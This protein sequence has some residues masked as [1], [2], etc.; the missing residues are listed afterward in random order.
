MSLL[1]NQKNFDCHLARTG[2]WL[3]DYS[4]SCSQ[5]NSQENNWDFEACWRVNYDRSVWIFQ[6]PSSLLNV[7]I[8][9]TVK[10]LLGKKRTWLKFRSQHQKGPNNRGPNKPPGRRSHFK[11][12]KTPKRRFSNKGEW[13]KEWTERWGLMQ[14][15]ASDS[16]PARQ[17]IPN[18][19]RPSTLRLVS[20]KYHGHRKW[21]AGRHYRQATLYVGTKT[22]K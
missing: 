4:S 19:S 21:V 3:S 7:S 1:E 16:I 5:E 14:I 17:A 22:K 12:A 11:Q 15:K 13:R 9:Q 20:T 6:V 10:S 2:D 18:F 8:G